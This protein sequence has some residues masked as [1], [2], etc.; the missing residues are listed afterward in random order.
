MLFEWGWLGL[1]QAN[2]VAVDL[3]EERQFKIFTLLR[4]RLLRA[5][6]VQT[7]I[8]L[9]VR[10]NRASSGARPAIPIKLDSDDLLL[11]FAA[12]FIGS[13]TCLS[14]HIAPGAARHGTDADASILS[15]RRI[16]SVDDFVL[17]A[18]F[19]RNIL[20]VIRLIGGRVVVCDLL[21]ADL[22]Y[23]DDALRRLQASMDLDLRDVR[24]VLA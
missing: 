10:F 24:R 2:Q 13:T 5:T 12:D 23:V 6:A 21:V 15:D 20:H 11:R 7:L 14:G 3:R 8:S 18:L 9:L 17:A 22:F 19:G 16:D 4:R 1:V